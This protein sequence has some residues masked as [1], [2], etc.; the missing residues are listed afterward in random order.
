MN[1]GVGIA[2]IFIYIPAL[3]RIISAG[4]V[5]ADRNVYITRTDSQKHLTE[6]SAP[7]RVFGMVNQARR[8]VLQRWGTRSNGFT[9]ICACFGREDECVC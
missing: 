7:I 5:N 1:K 3:G 4:R 9:N 2:L 8:L 6:I